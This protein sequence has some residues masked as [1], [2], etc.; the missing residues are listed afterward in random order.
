LTKLIH[1]NLDFEPRKMYLKNVYSGDIVDRCLVVFFASPYSY[2]G[3][4][5]AEIHSHGGYF[6]SQKIIDT[7]IELGATLA[8]KGEFSKRAFINGKMSI[9][10]AEGVMDLIN[11]ESEM[12]AKAG[13]SL[14]QGKLKEVITN[15]QNIL[16][17][18]LAEIEAKLDYPEYEYDDNETKNLKERLIDL[19]SNLENLIDE[20]KSGLIIKNGIKVA[21]V[22]A[23]N[24][25]KSSLLNALSKTD[26][27]IVTDIAGTTRDVIE[28]EYEY[29][30]IIFRLYDTAG[31][32]ESDDVVEKIGINRALKAIDDCD[33][34]LKISTLN[35]ICNIKTNKPTIEVFNKADIYNYNDDKYI[36]ISALTM[37]NVEKLKQLIFEK[38]VKEDFNS[39]KLY[40]TNTR[41]IE[42]IKK[43]KKAIDNVLKIFDETTMDIIS[44]EIKSAWY[45]LGEITGVTSD[46]NIIDKIFSKFCL[47]K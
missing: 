32:H 24:V 20:S 21:I 1:E 42:C 36:Y 13:S 5:V 4:D 35:N 6:L 11:A 46:E 34:V 27:A 41:H 22:G 33:I 15:Y 30:G 7:T 19:R 25:G 18:I 43:A 12:Q 26:K 9:D 16:T 23:P 45:S 14:L 3:E 8:G 38:T 39:N 31:I 17:D 44:S 28:A 47:G 29:N 10:Q 37:K 2:T 40:L